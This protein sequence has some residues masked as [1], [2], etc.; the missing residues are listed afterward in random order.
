MYLSYC[1]AFVVMVKKNKIQ[2]IFPKLFLGTVKHNI[3][4]CRSQIRTEESKTNCILLL[5]SISLTYITYLLILISQYIL[6]VMQFHL[7]CISIVYFFLKEGVTK[8]KKYFLVMVGYTKMF[9][10]FI[11]FVYLH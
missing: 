4:M 1:S 2:N 5:G 11:F 9:L 7:T 10:S 3:R 8:N 6:L